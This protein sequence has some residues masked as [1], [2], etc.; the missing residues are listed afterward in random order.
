MSQLNLLLS[1]VND[2]LDLKMIKEGKYDPKLEIFNPS[3]TLDF[4]VS[5]FQP[6]SQAKNTFVSHHCVSL[7][8]FSCVSSS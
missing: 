6:H 1:L 7:K 3:L 8:D 2:M 4:I 5:M